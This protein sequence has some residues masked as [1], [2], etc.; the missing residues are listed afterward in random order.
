MSRHEELTL[1]REQEQRL[2]EAFKLIVEA[3]L[4]PVAAPPPDRSFWRRPLVVPAL[5][6][7]AVL[8]VFL[9]FRLIGDESTEPASDVTLPSQESPATTLPVAPEADAIGVGDASRVEGATVFSDLVIAGDA[10]YTVGVGEVDQI[11]RS[12]DEG[13]SWE[14]VLTADPGDAEGLF[15]IGNLVVQV[16]EDDNPARDSV[17]PGS[18]V[19]ESPRVLV[20]DPATGSSSET[21]LPRPEDPQ[22]TGLPMDGSS[23]CALAGYQSFVRAEGVAVG[24][25]LLVVGNHQLVGE[26]SSGEVICDNQA[27]RHLAWVSDDAGANWALHDV[28][29]LGSI[30]WTGQRFA[31]WS[32]PDETGVRS[33]LVSDDGVT[34]TTA[35]TTPPTGEGLIPVGPPQLVASGERVIGLAEFHA[36]AAEIPE[37]VTDPEDLREAL[38]MGTDPES[39]PAET[40]AMLGIDLPLDDN[41]R[42]IIERFNGSTRPAGAYII[43]SD[44]AGATWTIEPSGQAVTGVAI[45]GSSYIALAPQ[46]S[47]TATQ[48]LSSTSGV[49]WTQIA[50]LPIT[51]TESSVAATAEAIFIADPNTGDLWTLPI[52][53]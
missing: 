19:S 18:A 12:V 46:D 28:P 33:I 42:E 13:R 40:L 26:L 22:M 10:F 37:N 17:E 15:S 36:W 5:A 44:D 48:I 11:L 6:F 32:P 21:T 23:G 29:A 31:G 43:T 45:A 52:Q 2:S 35:A 38:G 24:D 50:D 8:A 16:I 27:Y 30:V 4:I 47:E 51:G 53:D 34:W 20:Y 9:P 41:E 25:R 39:S 14:P 7:V 1:T 49:D 3:E